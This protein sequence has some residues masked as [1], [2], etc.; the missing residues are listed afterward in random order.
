M[1]ARI[2]PSI[3]SSALA[4]EWRIA[5]NRLPVQDR[6]RLR[7]PLFS[8][9]PDLAG[10]WGQWR[11]G[12]IQ[13][14]ELKEDL[15]RRH[16]WY[17]VVDVLRHEI[18]HQ[19]VETLFPNC[20][21]PPHGPHFL[22]MC[23]LL[24]ARPQASGDYPTLDEVIYS[25]QS[26][27]QNQE[28]AVTPQA[29][30]LLKIRKLLSLSESA[31]ENEARAALLKARELE[32]KFAQEYGETSQYSNDAPDFYTINIGP[33]LKR[34]TLKHS[35][36][37]NILQEFYHVRVIWASLPDIE[38]KEAG[39]FRRQLCLNGSRKDLR[40]ATYVYDCLTAYIARALYDLPGALLGK[41]LTHAKVRQDFE[42]GVL[43]GFQSALREQNQRPE[44]RALVLCD[45][46]RLEDYY[47]WAFPHL[48]TNRHTY[49]LHSQEARS[50]GEV[51]GRKFHLKHGL[52]APQ[53][54]P[55]QLKE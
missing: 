4:E 11:G 55:R 29:R 10:R 3:I 33:L 7:L 45:Q 31:N 47:H 42:I 52:E 48:R 25:D 13:C 15:L 14:I 37:G 5:V 6:E 24:G 44:M 54:K 22:T 43:S 38:S 51:A 1:P 49:T 20:D 23:S 12:K 41:A 21:E 16:P 46:T 36:L 50:A 26:D 28:G 34:I 8:V 27:A 32:A 35:I 2:H 53:E 17:A 39:D 18:A 9:L 19:A 30:L 40:I